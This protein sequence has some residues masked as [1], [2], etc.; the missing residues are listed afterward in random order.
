[1][2]TEPPISISKRAR[3]A[4]LGAM[5]G[6][7]LGST[8]E[9]LS[10]HKA[11]AAVQ[12]YSKFVNGLVG[13]GHFNLLPG[14]FTDDTEM[15]LAIMSVI[16]ESGAYNQILVSDAYHRWYLSDPFDIG[17]A[18]MNAVSNDNAKDMIKAANK[19]NSSSLSNGFLMR[20][21]GLVGL[22]HSKSSEEL[23]NAVCQDVVLTHSFPET[24][25][26]AI[27]YAM[28]LWKAIR[29]EDANTIYWWGRKHCTESPLLVAIYYAVDNNK[30]RFYYNCRWYELREIDSSIF[31]F[32]GFA[33]WLLLRALKF[34]NSYSD[35]IIEIV[36]YGGDT[37]TNAC[38][39]GAVMAALYPHTVPSK[40][41]DNVLNCRAEK[42][43]SKY[44]FAD[45]KIWSKW[46]PK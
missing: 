36:E 31:G 12:K 38:I 3:Y 40:W 4:I 5:V 19:Y 17:N 13:G 10:T 35:A 28:I 43:Y 15:A 6:D 37:D 45:P 44:A 24:I 34:H 21:F 22:Y 14:Q 18:T 39:V 20:L 1:M 27:V 11:K 25:H 46:L 2:S 16:V 41:I 29:G 7:S 9:F 8:L 33:F 32:V 42:R 23:V 26:I 30:D